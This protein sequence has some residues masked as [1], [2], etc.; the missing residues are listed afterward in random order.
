[1]GNLIVLDIELSAIR[2]FLIVVINAADTEYL[3]IKNRSDAGEFTHY[4]DE[5]NAYFIPEMWEKIAIR[6]GLGELNALVERELTYIAAGLPSVKNEKPQKNQPTFASDPKIWTNIK[7]IE[8]HYGINIK[9]M[10]N[11]ENVA[12]LR[13]KVNSFKHRNG[14]KHPYRDK[15]ETLSDRFIISREDAYSAIKS[16]RSFLRD[17]WS[18]TTRK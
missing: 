8:S 17:V 11:Y 15:C 6:A 3:A 4:D 12:D 5:A 18:I 9:E 10:S 7:R 16:V 2:S 14:Y 13:D 1:M